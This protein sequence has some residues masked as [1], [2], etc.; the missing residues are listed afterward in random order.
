[1]LERLSEEGRNTMR[2][3]VREWRH[4]GVSHAELK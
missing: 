1:M 4:R 3:H 2:V